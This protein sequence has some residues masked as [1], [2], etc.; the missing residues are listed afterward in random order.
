MGNEQS[1]EIIENNQININENDT[2]IIDKLYEFK[3][4]NTS[5][6]YELN[7]ERIKNIETNK[8]ELIIAINKCLNIFI[9][10]LSFKDRPN[11]SFV[12]GDLPFYGARWNFSL[13]DIPELKNYENKFDISGYFFN[14]SNYI[15]IIKLQF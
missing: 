3:K 14:E 11:A 9:Y 5:K 6:Y 15:I 12:K 10:D 1:Y 13:S 4:Y 8:K 2:L 7:T